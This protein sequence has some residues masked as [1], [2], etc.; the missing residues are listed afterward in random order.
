[1]SNKCKAVAKVAGVSVGVIG[2]LVAGYLLGGLF[3]LTL[4]NAI[5]EFTN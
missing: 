1:M 3:S 5:D 2:Y 4:G